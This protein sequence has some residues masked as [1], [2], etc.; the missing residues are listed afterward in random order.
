MGF[1]SWNNVTLKHIFVFII[2]GVIMY[3]VIFYIIDNVLPKKYRDRIHSCLIR[4]N[5]CEKITKLRDDE[6]LAHDTTD[7]STCLFTTWELSHVIYHSFLGYFFNFYISFISGII[8]EIFEHE[9]FNCGSYLDIFWNFVGFLIGYA[10][11]TI[12]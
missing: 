6:Y 5:N 1:F 2:L 12:L 10:L 9:V 8:F 4:C 11:R 7:L 3:I